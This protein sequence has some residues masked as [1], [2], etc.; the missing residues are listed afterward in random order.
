VAA[1][2]GISGTALMSAAGGAFLIYIGIRGVNPVDELRTILSGATPTPLDR[3]AKGTGITVTSTRT[4]E[5]AGGTFAPASN[6]GIVNAAAKYLGKPYRWG[7]T[8][9]NAFDC[10]GLVY[11]ALRESGY[12]VRRLTTFGWMVSPMA[13]TVQNPEP[14]DLVVWPG[15]MGIYVG[16][17]RMIEA[18]RTGLTVRYAPV[19]NRNGVAPTY[20]RVKPGGTGAKA[21]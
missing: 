14:G 8:G 5:F 10:S 17:G 3:T 21:A 1:T 13:V 20:R 6:S 2:R 12:Q 4:G 9:P 7:A 16:G 19:G 11:R 18:P 15:H